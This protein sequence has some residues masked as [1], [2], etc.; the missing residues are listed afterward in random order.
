MGVF[1]SA[2]PGQARM[3]AWMLRLLQMKMIESQPLVMNPGDGNNPVESTFNRPIE[4]GIVILPPISWR[5]FQE[6]RPYIINTVFFEEHDYGTDPFITTAGNSGTHSVAI[7][8]AGG[9][10]SAERGWISVSDGSETE[11]PKT[12]T[13]TSFLQA[14]PAMTL[15]RKAWGKAFKLDPAN[16]ENLPFE[17]YS[18]KLQGNIGTID[19][20]FQDKPHHIF[21]SRGRIEVKNSGNNSKI[22]EA[23]QAIGFYRQGLKASA[24]GQYEII[25]LTDTA[26]I[27]VIGEPGKALTEEN[28]PGPTLEQLRERRE[29]IL[30]WH[31]KDLTNPLWQDMSISWD[32]ILKVF[33]LT[34]D[35]LSLY[36]LIE[37]ASQE[38]RVLEFSI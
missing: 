19:E 13:K 22:I 20:L 3:Y 38:Q 29:A 18:V 8:W 7:P 31:K 9:N 33:N 14:T 16:G 6:G 28:Y 4:V 2:N 10:S 32:V 24:W 15:D 26:Q 17:I 27:F 30:L 36:D 34:K 11:Q 23:G 5:E 1:L 12:V 37:P 35:S 21:V 25:P